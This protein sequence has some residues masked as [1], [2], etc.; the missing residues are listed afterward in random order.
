MKRILPS[1]LL[2]LLASL[3]AYGAGQFFTA[4]GAR[5]LA[6]AGAFVAGA[7]DLE[8]VYWNPAGISQTGWISTL[9]DMGFLLQRVHYDR[10]DSG[11]NRLPGVDDNNQVLPMPMVA[12][13]WRPNVANQRLTFALAAFTPYS[14]IPR[15]PV[16]GP[17]RYSE[18]SLEGSTMVTLELAMSVRIL[19]QLYLGFGFQNLFASFRNQSV[20]AGCTQL[21]CAPEDPNFDSPTEFNASSMFTPSGNIGALV[22]LP[23]YVRIGASFQ[24]PYFIRAKGKAK[25]RLP[26]DPLYDGA[27]M[28]GDRMDAVFD[29]PWALRAGVEVRPIPALRIE[30]AGSYEAWQMHDRVRFIPHGIF[31]DNMVLA[32]TYELK[33]T[34]LERNMQGVFSLHIGGEFEAIKNRLSVLA[35]YMYETSGIPDET[36]TVL[37]PDG[38]KHLLSLG[39]AVRIGKVRLDLSYGHVFQADRTVTN[40]RSMQLAPMQPSIAVPVGNGTYKVANDVIAVGVEARF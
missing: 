6:R 35:G 33:E 27:V 2:V 9:I 13:S 1:L 20:S 26:S 34:V 21:D 22:V 15:Y 5:P 7:D 3:P 10:V 40:S 32:K 36:L 19:P 23:P 4:R 38:E 29:F 28:R 31:V 18:V 37:T 8:A 30:V 39:V 11:G 25:S 17:Q 24:L 14:G 16:D 12:V